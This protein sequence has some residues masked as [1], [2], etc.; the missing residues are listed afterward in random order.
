MSV[1]QGAFNSGN[2]NGYMVL[3]SFLKTGYDIHDRN[4]KTP[5]SSNPFGMNAPQLH[6][7]SPTRV[8]KPKMEKPPSNAHTHKKSADLFYYNSHC[9]D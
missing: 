8:V 7:D 2:G 1:S 3:S 5:Y 9:I 4:H 6:K